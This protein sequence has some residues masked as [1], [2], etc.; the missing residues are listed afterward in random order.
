MIYTHLYLNNIDH[1][2]AANFFKVFSSLIWLDC[3]NVLVTHDCK[4]A[5]DPYLMVCDFEKTIDRKSV[6]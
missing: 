6:V 5:K 4:P 1:N 2:I 3:N